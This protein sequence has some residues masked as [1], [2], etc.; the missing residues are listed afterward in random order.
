MLIKFNHIKD[1][2]DAR[3]AAAA[4]AEWIGFS[5]GELP[6]QQVQEIVGWCAGPKITLEVGNTDTLESVQS[7][8]NLLPVEAIECPQEDVDF[9]K[10]HLLADYQYI[11]NTSDNQSIALG[12]PNITIN[13]VHP[14]EQSASEIKALNPVAISLDCEKDMVVGM[15]NYDLWNDLLETLEIW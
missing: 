6:I 7:W 10:Q 2:S 12:D 1:L 5:V 3:Y 13:K 4:M 8:C 11:L 15:K 9:W 14:S